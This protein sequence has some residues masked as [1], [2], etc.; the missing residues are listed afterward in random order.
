MRALMLGILVLV[1]SSRAAVFPSSRA[2][3]LPKAPVHVS[4]ASPISMDQQLSPGDTVCVIGASGNVG[5]LVA[6]RLAE[7]FNKIEEH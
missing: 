6:L 7:K 3:V 5:K 2:A 4:R 1:T